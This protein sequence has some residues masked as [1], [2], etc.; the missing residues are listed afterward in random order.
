MNWEE[1]LEKRL[2][3]LTEDDPGFKNEKSRLGIN[4]SLEDY[5]DHLRFNERDNQQMIEMGR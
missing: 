2:S 4:Y 5:K 1:K 3:E